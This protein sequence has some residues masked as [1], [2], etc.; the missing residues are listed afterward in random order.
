MSI[1]SSNNAGIQESIKQWWIGVKEKNFTH[2]ADSSRIDV[3]RDGNVAL[4]LTE[5]DSQHRLRYLTVIG[6]VDL[7]Y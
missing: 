6:M 4:L 2:S 3:L 7:L 5:H 1:L